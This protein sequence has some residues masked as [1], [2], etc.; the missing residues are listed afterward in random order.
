VILLIGNGPSADTPLVA[1]AIGKASRVLRMNNWQP[2]IHIGDRC[3]IWGTSFNIDIQERVL[4]AGVEIW[5]SGWPYGA[6]YHG[7]EHYRMLM[8]G[9]RNRFDR[10]P[11]QLTLDFLYNG[12]HPSTGLIMAVM[13]MATGEPV[14]LAGFDHFKGDRHHYWTTDPAICDPAQYHNASSEQAI[15]EKLGVDILR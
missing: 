11:G 10:V 13:A 6:F 4:P 14:T 9:Q 3:D 12:Y 2:G 7:P 8:S 1:D 5:W 15:L